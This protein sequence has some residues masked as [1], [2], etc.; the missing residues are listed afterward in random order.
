M[1]QCRLLPLVICQQ[2]KILWHLKFFLTQDH[3][4]LE[5]SKRY[6]SSSFLQTSA[7][8]YEDIGYH[9]AI[10]AIYFLANWPSLKRCV[11]L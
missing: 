1:G 6:C 8:L 4:G 7:K 10:E 5:M 2:L 3:M 11:P 9:G